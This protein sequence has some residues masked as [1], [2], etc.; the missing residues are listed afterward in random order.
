[1]VDEQ[2]DRLASPNG[3]SRERKAAP[4]VKPRTHW[5]ARWPLMWK[6]RRPCSGDP[7]NPPTAPPTRQDGSLGPTGRYFRMRA[8]KSVVQE[9]G[10]AGSGNLFLVAEKIDRPAAVIELRDSP[11]IC[12]RRQA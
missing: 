11:G 8:G 2:W 1:M 7:R 4:N 3:T 9:G 6:L 5:P 10:V 12:I